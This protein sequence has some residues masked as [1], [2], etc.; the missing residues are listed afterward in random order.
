VRRDWSAP[1]TYTIHYINRRHPTVA[2]LTIAADE[3]KI[4]ALKARLD[5][6]GYDIIDISPANGIGV[7][8]AAIVI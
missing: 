5:L 3:S 8:P 2:G 6:D 7:P 1:V 4:D